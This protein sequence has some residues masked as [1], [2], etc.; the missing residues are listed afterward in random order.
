M[1]SEENDLKKLKKCQ[2]KINN[3]VYELTS[4]SKAISKLIE[5]THDI[6]KKAVLENNLIDLNTSLTDLKKTQ[7]KLR[8]SILLWKD[9]SNKYDYKAI[10][11]YK[12]IKDKKRANDALVSM[13]FYELYNV[14]KSY[15]LLSEL[16][17]EYPSLIPFL[18]GEALDPNAIRKRVYRY[19]KSNRTQ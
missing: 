4:E 12:A 5:K 3:I 6:N 1:L 16:L 10:K 2:N 18:T 7:K 14:I 9:F 8:T 13:L 19:T 15:T 11:I 17:V